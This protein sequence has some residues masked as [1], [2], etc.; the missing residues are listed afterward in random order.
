M[1][2]SGT[3]ISTPKFLETNFCIQGARRIVFLPATKKSD[4]GGVMAGRN[5]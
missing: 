3:L 5:Q 1:Y 4:H 2:T